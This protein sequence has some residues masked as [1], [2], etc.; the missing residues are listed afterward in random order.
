MLNKE[1]TGKRKRGRPQKTHGC[2]EGG[3]AE[4]WSVTKEDDRSRVRWRQIICCGD[5]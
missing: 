4:G 5:H 3:H 1:L 2:D